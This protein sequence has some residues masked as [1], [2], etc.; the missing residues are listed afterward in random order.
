[1][2]VWNSLVRRPGLLIAAGF[3][4]GGVSVAGIIGGARPAHAD[5]KVALAPI[6]NLTVEAQRQLTDLDSSFAALA[7]Y[8]SPAIVHIRVNETKVQGG[9]GP[10]RT[11]GQGSGFIYRAD[12][13]IITNDH[14]VADADKVTVILN[15]GRE[16]SGT[17]T[18]ANDPQVD[19]A[20]VKVDAKNLPTAQFADSD[21]VKTGQFALAFG[22]PYGLENTMTVGHISA[23][24]RDSAIPDMRSGSVRAYSSLIQTDAPINPGNSG[25]PLVN[26]E[27]QVIGINTSIYSE[28][29]S[30][31]GQGGNVGIGFAIPSN[32]VKVVADILI[33]KGKLSRG[34]LGLGLRDLKPFEK[35][36]MGIPAGAYVDRVE[37]GSPAGKAG[38][39]KD[40]VVVRVGSTSVRSQQD[41]RLSMFRYEP[42]AKVQLEVLRGGKPT[43][44]TVTVDKVPSPVA[45]QTP[46]ST[47]P[48]SKSFQWDDK[49]RLWKEQDGNDLFKDFDGMVT[50]ELREE[51]RKFREGQ[52]KPAPKAGNEAPAGKPR[53]GVSVTDLNDAA[54]NSGK[55][56]ADVRGAWV[57]SVSPDS[58]AQSVGI[59]EGDVITSVNG[60]KVQTADDLIAA[61]RAVPA[62]GQLSITWERFQDG[63]RSKNSATITLK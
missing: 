7:D 58:L 26:V 29:A 49:N 19:I 20:I 56:P 41:L 8:V 37:A 2:K 13:Y 47:A 23:V 16:I 63:A 51:M 9:I 57:G 1:M 59:Q 48:K 34:Y 39:K 43:N 36:E 52:T 15:D 5:P 3:V 60:K 55:I 32:Q 61:I 50:P 17:V 21:Q 24:G 25:G 45:M 18:R 53:L 44:I 38:L 46:E 11:Q 30:I 6:S 42:G 28:G 62:N 40:D 12:G 27:G 54:R 22:A 35:K 31:T 14:V 33:E 10:M 4:I